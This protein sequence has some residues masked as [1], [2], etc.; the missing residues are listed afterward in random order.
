MG[1]LEVLPA[2]I[3]DD[4]PRLKILW[5]NNNL[6]MSSLDY[7]QSKL[8]PDSLRRLFLTGNERMEFKQNNL[9]QACCS[10]CGVS[11]SANVKAENDMDFLK[12][13]KTTGNGSCDS[14]PKVQTLACCG[15]R[16]C[17]AHCKYDYS[18]DTECSYWQLN[19]GAGAATRANLAV[20]LLLSLGVVCMLW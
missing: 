10:L 14:K 11:Q 8:W 5:E 4:L 17:S 6:S 9:E 16:N 13:C 2:G 18:T 3:F 1:N 19:V 7:E 15:Y 12:T 20:T